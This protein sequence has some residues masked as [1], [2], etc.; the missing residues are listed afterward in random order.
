M[1]KIPRKGWRCMLADVAI[2]H[3]KPGE[4]AIKLADGAGKFLLIAPAGG[5][6]WRLKYR[7]D[8]REMLLPL[9]PILKSV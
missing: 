6:H 7:F 1:G 5:K 4:K 9:G 8:R 2:R 3:V